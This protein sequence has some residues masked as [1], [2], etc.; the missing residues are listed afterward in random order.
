MMEY[1]PAGDYELVTARAS[2]CANPQSDSLGFYYLYGAW[3]QSSPWRGGNRR[4]Y[5]TGGAIEGEGLKLEFPAGAVAATAELKL[6]VAPD[7]KPDGAPGGLEAPS[8]A[9]T[10]CPTPSAPASPSPSTRRSRRTDRRTSCSSPASTRS[11]GRR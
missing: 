7:A 8:T 2:V 4:R 11:A 9:S 1:L 5:A 10:G 6:M 3:R